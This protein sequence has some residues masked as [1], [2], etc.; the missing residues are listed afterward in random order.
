MKNINFCQKIVVYSDNQDI[1]TRKNQLESFYKAAR[2]KFSNSN[3]HICINLKNQVAIVSG[4]DLK[5]FF[6]RLTKYIPYI[7]SVSAEERGSVY[8]DFFKAVLDET[9]AK[10][11]NLE[12]NSAENILN[13]MV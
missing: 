2:E 9:G 11:I 10:K 5:D 7:E 6:Q 8:L 12:S 13:L 3:N 1:K 4:E